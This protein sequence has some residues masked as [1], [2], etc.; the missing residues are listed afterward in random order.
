MRSSSASLTSAAF[1]DRRPYGRFFSFELTQS[2][3]IN[4]RTG[5]NLTNSA[6]LSSATCVPFIDARSLLTSGL[7]NKGFGWKK[8]KAFGQQQHRGREKALHSH[9]TNFAGS[10]AVACV[11]RR[12]TGSSSLVERRSILPLPKKK[13]PFYDIRPP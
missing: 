1:V 11:A 12:R 7:Q 13:S 2:T 6:V 4:K 8:K 9:R 5:N 3:G 10:V